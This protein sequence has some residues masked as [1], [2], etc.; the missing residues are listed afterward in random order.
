MASF[1]FI[2]TIASKLFLFKFEILED[3]WNYLLSE[4]LSLFT[5][6]MHC[7]VYCVHAMTVVWMSQCTITLALKWNRQ[8]ARLFPLP[9]V[10]W[11]LVWDLI[12]LFFVWTQSAGKRISCSG[13]VSNVHSDDRYNQMC[14]RRM[15][16]L[17]EVDGAFDRYYGPLALRVLLLYCL[18][19]EL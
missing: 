7:T 15:Y 8:V 19:L 16:K 4:I 5:H 2:A 9:M 14:L 12:E 13:R 11:S 18:L 17:P 10:E 6:T 1:K 3:A